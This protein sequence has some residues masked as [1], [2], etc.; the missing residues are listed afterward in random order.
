MFPFILKSDF[1]PNK[2]EWEE[3]IFEIETHQ[4]YNEYVYFYPYIQDI[5]YNK[6]ENIST[7][8]NYKQKGTYIIELLEKK[9][10]LDI[11]SINLRVF[12]NNIAILSFK[13]KNDKYNNPNDIL[14]INEYGRR[15]Y[16]QF[17][18]L[19]ETQKSFLAKSI[20]L[21][22]TNSTVTENFES[23]KN[24]TNKN[25]SYIPKFITHLLQNS[26]NIDEIKSILDDRMFVISQYN[27][28]DLT[29]KLQQYDENSGY[30]YEDY[31]FWYRY[32][33][34]DGGDKTCQ[35]RY[36]TK[37]LIKESTYDR[38]V[39]WGTL[40]GISRYSFVSLTGS[41]YGKEILL[42]HMQTIYFQ[43]FSLLLAYRAT[44]LYFADNIQDITSKE[45]KELLKESQKIY[46]K[47]LDFI[48]KLYF[49]EVTAQDQGIELYNKALKIM[50]ID[51][52][53]KDLDHEITELH[54]Y[55]EMIENKNET[56]QMNKL[57]I[58]GTYL[59]PPT[60][61]A[62]VFGMNIF[63]AKNTFAVDNWISWIIAIIATIL[64]YI[65]IFITKDKNE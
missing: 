12:K 42:P 54:R 13:L 34:V 45:D 62:G 22:L 25:K 44:I 28:D 60:V 29:S 14:E 24:F 38:W 16:P 47:Y 40:F 6:E 52:Y 9:Y 51:R 5:L 64:I 2:D 63:S 1:T 46:K 27:N 35:S 31:D 8:Y 53:L 61:V 30:K 43:M 23:F 32:I 37:Q 4:E 11:E 20:T 36:M 39:D 18:P 57:T 3:K 65:F 59:L 21:K 49:K 41:W 48:N 10:Q 26:I 7:Y 19:E 50:N 56:K 58:L 17:L 15:I 55:V 33:F